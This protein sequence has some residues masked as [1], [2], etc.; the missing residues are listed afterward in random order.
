M[1]K[2]HVEAQGVTR[3]L[4]PE[5]SQ[6]CSEVGYGG[7]GGTKLLPALWDMGWWHREQLAVVEK[8]CEGVM[9]CNQEESARASQW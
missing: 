2:K 7:F 6:T 4:S 9:R 1:E 5:R 3:V 8:T